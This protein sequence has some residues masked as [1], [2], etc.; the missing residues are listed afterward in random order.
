[1]N[2][3]DIVSIH[4]HMYAALY[5]PFLCIFR[6]SLFSLFVSLFLFFS[7]LSLSPSQPISFFCCVFLLFHSLSLSLYFLSI[8][9]LMFSF[10]SHLS[11]SFFSFLSFEVNFHSKQCYKHCFLREVSNPVQ[12]QV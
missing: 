9:L 6:T 3:V 2:H 10:F 1:M 8:S 4:I 11:F 5:K 7:S 12:E